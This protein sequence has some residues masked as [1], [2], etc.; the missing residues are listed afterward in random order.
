LAVTPASRVAVYKHAI[1]GYYFLEG[2]MFKSKLFSTGIINDKLISEMHEIL[3]IA[4]SSFKNICAIYPADETQINGKLRN[5]I[6]EKCRQE[7]ITADRISRAI[8]FYK[9]IRNAIEDNRESSE[10]LF[11]DLEENNIISIDEGKNIRLQYSDYEL[12][13][14]TKISKREQE[15]NSMRLA[16]PI[17]DH[18]HTALNTFSIIEKEYE[19]SE[20]CE[21]YEMGNVLQIPVLLVQIDINSFEKKDV[22]SFALRNFE[23]EQLINR[24]KLGL[25]QINSLETGK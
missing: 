18:I 6:L 22:V 7:G 9:Y 1:I 23:V 21:K 11:K 10:L 17:I 19:I 24:L 4:A 13:L 14:G 12:L 5:E 25:I 8:Y 16:F 2:F 3:S 15:D 20:D